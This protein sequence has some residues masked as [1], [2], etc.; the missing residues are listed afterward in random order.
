MIVRTKSYTQRDGYVLIAVLLVIVVLSLSAYQ[1]A[2]SMSAEYQVAYRSMEA[3]QAKAH[4]V[5]G[6]HYAA[7]ALADPDTVANVLAN[8]PYDCEQAFSNVSI[9]ATDGARKGGRFA[10]LNITD[11]GDA[12]TE[13]F[14]RKYGVTDESGKINLNAMVR[15]DSSGESLH[16]MLVLLPNMTEELADAIVDWLDED[17]DQRASG[18]EAGAYSEYKPK[19]GP[20]ST[21]DELLLVRG[22]TPELLY[23]NDRNRN[24]IQDAGESNGGDFS[25]GWSD[26]LTVYG[27]ELN[28]DSTGAPRYYVNGTTLAEVNQKIAEAAGQALADYA[29]AYRLY[30]VSSTLI[31]MPSRTVKGGPTELNAAVQQSLKSSGKAK[32][33]IANSLLTLVNTRVTLPRAP[34]AMPDAPSVVV[35][36]PLNSPEYLKT[37]LP[38]LLDKLTCKNG[39]EFNPRINVNTAPQPLL[40]VL[41]GVTPEDAAAAVAARANLSPGTAEYATGSWLVTQAGMRPD[42]FRQIERYITGYTQTYR[43]QSIGYFGRGGPVARV[44]AVIDINGGKP[45][46]VYF[47]DL[48]E[49]GLGFAPPRQ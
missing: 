49:L 16:A 17:E 19:N 47:R 20:L 25:R 27:R 48:T 37:I 15:I 34:G 14:T 46:I 38:M 9:G 29:I 13:K 7:A 12:S 33:S 5:S 23:G 24:G 6:V 18:A 26:Y 21:I 31:P 35:D 11:N 36:S 10:L 40:A 42:I 32:R 43:V 3:A 4:A 28:V 30:T 39:Y 44:E 8:N 22:V 45:R 41:P 1:F 2:D